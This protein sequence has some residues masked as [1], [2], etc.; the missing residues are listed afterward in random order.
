VI[1]HFVNNAV[2]VIMAYIQG[3]EKF[4][5]TIDTPLWKQ[6]LTLPLPIVIGLVILFHFR[7]KSRNNNSS[8]INQE[9]VSYTDP[10]NA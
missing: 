8:E 5:A 10:E 7:N 2:P 1:S 4:S 6:A 3:M 9:Q